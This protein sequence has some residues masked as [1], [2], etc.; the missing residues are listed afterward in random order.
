MSKKIRSYEDLTDTQWK[1][2]L[3]KAKGLGHV[4]GANAAEWI[5]QESWGGRAGRNADSTAKAFLKGYEDGDPQVM[6]AYRGPDLSGEYSGDMTV[7]KLYP[8]LGL[9][10][11]FQDT[12]DF[13]L[14]QEYEDGASESFY[15]TL[16]MSAKAYL[17]IMDNPR[18]PPKVLR[19]EKLVL[20]RSK[21]SG[22]EGWAI[23]LY[24]WPQREEYITWTVGPGDE[25]Q[26][27][28][29]FPERA[30]AEEDFLRR[31]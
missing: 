4:H 21:P 23:E 24:Y 14:A 12:D 15:D 30:D 22:T 1:A 9:P 16:V 11:G 8:M 2:A 28:H 10:D 20:L 19:F 17:S 7:N 31:K 25:R 18:R 6:D 27:G 3:A 13:E 26:S 5:I 29:Y